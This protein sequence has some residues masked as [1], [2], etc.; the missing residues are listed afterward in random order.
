VFVC[1]DFRRPGRFSRVPYFIILATAAT[2]HRAGRT[3]IG[4]AAEAAGA[5]RP[6]AGDA[7]TALMALGL[8]GTGLLAVPVL[9]GS[10]GY[11]VCE[12]FGWKCS[13]DAKPGKAKEFYLVLGLATLGGL[14]IAFSGV[15]PM[16]AL[17]GTAVINGLLAPP[18]LVV[19]M[20]IA[21]HEAVM[22]RRVNGWWENV[23]GW[24]TTVVMFAA[25]V[26]FVLTW[27]Q[28]PSP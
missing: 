24:A 14:L 7:A 15:S 10:A 5:L 12:A 19:I 25:A 28:P 17:F 9:T 6:L 13:L 26:A 3:D 8:V 21:N 4:S 20:L 18:L 16:A 22:G 11:A 2:L 27:G 1:K 23:L